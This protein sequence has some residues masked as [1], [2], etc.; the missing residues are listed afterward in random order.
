MFISSLFAIPNFT[1]LLFLRSLIPLN[2]NLERTLI[3]NQKM[4][5]EVVHD[6]ESLLEG[7]YDEPVRLN[8]T[9]KYHNVK[10]LRNRSP[11]N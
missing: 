8:Q 7:I 2:M 1:F 3:Y 6:Q 4:V 5:N 10:R 9:L 11:L